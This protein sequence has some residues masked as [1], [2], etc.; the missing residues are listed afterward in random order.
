MKL[1]LGPDDNV[2]GVEFD[3]SKLYTPPEEPPPPSFNELWDQAQAAIHQ[4]TTKYSEEYWERASMSENVPASIPRRHEEY[5]EFLSLLKEKKVSPSGRG[6]TRR[7]DLP[8]NREVDAAYVRIKELKLN[9][10]VTQIALKNRPERKHEMKFAPLYEQYKSL[11]G[12][13][14]ALPPLNNSTLNDAWVHWLTLAFMTK[15]DGKPEKSKVLLNTVHERVKRTCKNKPTAADY[16]K[17]IKKDFK[18][19]IPR[20]AREL[21]KLYRG[22]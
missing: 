9:G 19:A 15:Y 14:F 13:I 12:Q 1:K 5:R 16:R 11:F 7:A 10:L 2:F 18:K 17:E 4:L 20:F 6:K 21:S 8:I 22:T 3:F